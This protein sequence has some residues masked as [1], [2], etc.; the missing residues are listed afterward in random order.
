[1]PA[2]VWWVPYILKKCDR[3]ISTVNKQCFRFTHKF[4]IE[5]PK[6]V[7]CTLEIDKENGNTL[8]RDAIKKEMKNAYM[9]SRYRRGEIPKQFQLIE[10]HMTFN[11]KMENNLRR[12]ARLMAGGHMTEAPDVP[13]YASVILRET[14][15]IALTYA[16]LNDLEVKG[17]DIQN[18]YLSAP[19]KEKIYTKLGPEFR[20][21]EG[22]F[23]IITRALY[24]LKFAGASFN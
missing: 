14:M 21:D 7:R 2:F 3:I 12:K 6:T 11:A 20:P 16:A 9:H 1:M 10:C 22:N 24:G 5:I 23:A 8:W 18:A 15:R 17:A 4:G 13:T 19:C